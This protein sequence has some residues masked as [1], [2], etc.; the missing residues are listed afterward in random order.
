LGKRIL[1]GGEGNLGRG[2]KKKKKKATGRSS[3]KKSQETM[4]VREK[5]RHEKKRNE[6]PLALGKKEGG[7]RCHLRRPQIDKEGGRKGKEAWGEEKLEKN[8]EFSLLERGVP[9]ASQGKEGKGKKEKTCVKSGRGERE[10]FR[11]ASKKETWRATN[12]GIGLK[13]GTG[14]INVWL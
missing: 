11:A 7:V 5:T 14:S 9:F 4:E 13:E 12:R 8:E 2:G 3:W 1:H 10:F 6:I